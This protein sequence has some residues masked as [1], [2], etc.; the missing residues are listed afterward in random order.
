M[1]VNPTR[2]SLFTHNKKIFRFAPEESLIF[3]MFAVDFAD[4][5]HDPVYLFVVAKAQHPPPSV[6]AGRTRCSQVA[7]WSDESQSSDTD[8]QTD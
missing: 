7:V 3:Q 1:C 2:G 5:V 6:A 8:M 4:G